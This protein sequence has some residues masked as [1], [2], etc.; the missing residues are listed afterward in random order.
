MEW[1]Y[2]YINDMLRDE[3]T[4]PCPNL[5]GGLAKSLS[6]KRKAVVSMAGR[7]WGSSQ[8]FCVIQHFTL[9]LKLAV[10]CYHISLKEMCA[11]SV[12]FNCGLLIINNNLFFEKFDMHKY[13]T[14]FVP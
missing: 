10:I 2:N 11:T 1:I 13:I 8:M 4:H 9:G 14:I 5:D 6:D 7:R 3:I 12:P